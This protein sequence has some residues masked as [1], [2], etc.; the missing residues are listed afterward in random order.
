MAS[1]L[2][3]FSA[4]GQSFHACC[5][6]TAFGIAVPTCWMATSGTADR[7]PPLVPGGRAAATPAHWTATA[8][9]ASTVCLGAAHG[10]A[11]GG[12][13]RS[14]LPAAATLGATGMS[15]VA[16][17]IAAGPALAWP[18][19]MR[20][21]AHSLPRFGTAGTA[22]AAERKEEPTDAAISSSTLWTDVAAS[23]AEVFPTMLQGSWPPCL[24]GVS[25]WRSSGAPRGRSCSPAPSPPPAVFPCS[26]WTR[27]LRSSRRIAHWYETASAAAVG[28]PLIRPP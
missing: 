20:L 17:P 22:G 12:G 23:Q 18:G 4:A 24:A 16:A 27:L 10:G 8:L 15:V 28:R 21:G 19:G 25:A 1:S 14:P 6:G 2:H 5:T 9:L 26:A 11:W 7:M 3:A 13:P